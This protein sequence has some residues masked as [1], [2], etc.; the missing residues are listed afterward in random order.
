MEFAHLVFAVNPKAR[1]LALSHTCLADCAKV[2]QAAAP[3]AS[4]GERPLDGEAVSSSAHLLGS[5]CS[6]G[7]SPEKTLNATN[8]QIS[9]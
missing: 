9:S 8:H 6:T 2:P 5:F 4:L 1:R 3:A 7:I